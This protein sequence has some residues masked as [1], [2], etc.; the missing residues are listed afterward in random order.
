MTGY[1]HSVESFGTLDGPGIRFVVFLQGCPL[2][3]LYCHNPDTWE[4]KKGTETDAETLLAQYR[5][6][7]MF[8]TGGGLTVT[9]GEPLLQLDF[10]IGLFTLAKAEGIHT[11]LDTSGACYR[12]DDAAY[13]AQIDKLLDVTDLVMLDIKHI[14]PEA[15]HRLTGMDNERVLR[16]AE[17]LD[18]RSVVTWVRHTVVEGYTDDPEA[19]Q[20]LGRFIGKLSCVKALD[21]LPYHTLGAAKYRELGL[22]YPLEG[23]AP[24]EKTAAQIAKSHIMSGIKEVRCP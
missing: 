1:V 14:D 4:A 18:R 15:H 22:R 24:L 8:Y 23:V 16:F 7:R 19:L 5:K 12:P 3:C 11:C 20:A 2:R 21:V 10:L 17:H 13:A 9:G 6:N